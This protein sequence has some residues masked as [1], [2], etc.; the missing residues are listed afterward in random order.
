[1]TTIQVVLDEKLLKAADVAARRANQNRSELIREAL[2][3]H[4]RR[5]EIKAMEE[6]DRIGYAKYPDTSDDAAAWEAVEAWPEE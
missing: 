3:A 6:R 1:M 5:M 2:N 4:L